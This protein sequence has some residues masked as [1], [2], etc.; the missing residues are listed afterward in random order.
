MR[1]TARHG[2]DLR[3]LPLQHQR[4]HLLI[5]QRIRRLRPSAIS[6]KPFGKGPIAQA[7]GAIQCPG[8]VVIL[9]GGADRAL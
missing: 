6:A 1:L 3:Q 9:G 8:I 2:G 5:G 4:A 7:D